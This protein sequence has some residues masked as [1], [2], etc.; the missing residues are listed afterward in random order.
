MGSL[1]LSASG[2]FCRLVNEISNL[3]MIAAQCPFTGGPS[4]FEARSLLL[5]TNS[6]LVWED[7]V[8]CS[9]SSA[10]MTSKKPNYIFARVYPNPATNTISLQYDLTS[11]SEARLE[12][13][14]TEGR[15]LKNQNL[16]IKDFSIEI[17][18]SDLVNGIFY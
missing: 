13:I 9:G 15:K 2:L 8:L 16:D 5:L 11:Y 7:D 6:E 1:L 4:V 12:I 14:D 17:D 3:Q 10:R 18:I